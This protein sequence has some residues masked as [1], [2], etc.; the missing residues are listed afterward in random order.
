[1]N[2]RGIEVVV[3]TVLI[4]LVAVAGVGILW[5]GILPQVNKGVEDISEIPDFSIVTSQ[6]YTVYDPD[7]GI[8]SVQVKRGVKLESVLELQIIFYVSGSSYEFRVPVP[9]VSALP[10]INEARVYWFN[11]TKDNITGIPEYVSIAPIYSDG[12]I[13]EIISRVEMPVKKI[14]LSEEELAGLEFVPIYS[15]GRGKNI[16]N[17]VPEIKYQCNDGIDNDLDGFTDLDDLG[18]DNLIDNNE[19]DSNLCRTNF[20]NINGNLIMNPNVECDND[21]NGV[22]D[23]WESYRGAGYNITWIRDGLKDSRVLQSVSPGYT[24]Q[25]YG[26]INRIK[27]LKPNTWYEFSVNMATENIEPFL[28]SGKMNSSTIMTGVTLYQANADGQTST[29]FP[30]TIFW[31]N[32][33]CFEDWDEDYWV[34]RSYNNASQN[35]TTKTIYFK[36]SFNTFGAVIRTYNWPKGK[37]FVDDFFLRELNTDYSPEAGPFKKSGTLDFVQY[38]GTDFF[39]IFAHGYPSYKAPAE[40]KALGFNTVQARSNFK[41]QILAEDLAVSIDETFFNNPINEWIN[42]PNKSISFK[43]KQ[44]FIN[45]IN[46]WK[47]CP[48]LLMIETRDE[49]NNHYLVGEAIGNQLPSE[50]AEQYIRQN[51]PGKYILQDFGDS[52]SY[53]GSRNDT[54]NKYIRFADIISYTSNLQSSYPHESGDYR[55]PPR[56]PAIG[57]EVRWTLKA[58]EEAGNKKKVFAYGLGVPRWSYW[59]GVSGWHDNQYIPFNLQ[60]FQVWTQ[61]LNGAVGVWFWGMGYSEASTSST[62]YNATVNQYNFKIIGRIAT[63]LHSLYDVLLEKEFYDEW[64]VSDERVEIMMKK[65]NGKIYLFAA[66]THYED[67]QDIKITL[68]SK[69]TITSIKT[70]NDII[71][72]DINNPVN[73]TISV[74]SGKHSFNDDFIGDYNAGPGKLNSP[75]YA[76]HIYEIEYI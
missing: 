71:N 51:L 57:E 9:E 5:V 6:G 58:T 40:L 65:H 38:K 43:G 75:G 66:S 8:A 69:Y 61:I 31:A 19:S 10:G 76:V 34:Y 44:N 35:W 45:L 70:I 21:H 2:K 68:D 7:L 49:I 73:R 4:I 55:G 29:Y 46:E 33:P 1:M 3:A 30:R 74:N 42:D 25:T 26:W 52:W 64:Q 17:P 62:V 63:E 54:L 12:K 47:D 60:R 37:I 41:S 23:S 67:L 24:A 36:T 50:R 22:P 16:I 59:D 32:W 27:N 14:L 18:C 20:T 48:N 56:M 11:F 72:G 39:P 13:G 28:Y 53:T 15:P